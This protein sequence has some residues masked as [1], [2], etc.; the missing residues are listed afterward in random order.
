MVIYL[1]MGL[2][3]LL[4]NLWVLFAWGVVVDLLFLCPHPASLIIEEW[5]KKKTHTKHLAS[6]PSNT[7]LYTTS[8]KQECMCVMKGWLAI[9]HPKLWLVRV[10][11]KLK[12]CT[13]AEA[14]GQIS[15]NTICLLPRHQWRKARMLVHLLF[16]IF[17][18]F[19]GLL[20]IL[21]FICFYIQHLVG[22]CLSI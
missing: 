5:K 10:C 19:V 2:L 14:L 20:L 13:Q 9:Y 18:L 8:L 17:F 15:N 4:L 7:A 6:S 16:L 1:F 22:C 21:F 11:M 3:L 12:G